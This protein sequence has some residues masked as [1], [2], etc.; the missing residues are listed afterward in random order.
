LRRD[1]EE[2]LPIFQ[3][4][5]DSRRHL[6]KWVP[7]GPRAYQYSVATTWNISVDV[8]QDDQEYG[9]VAQSLQRLF[10]FLNPDGILLEFLER[11]VCAFSD[12][13]KDLIANDVRFDEALQLLQRFS[14]I[15]I[16]VIPRSVTIHRMVQ[17]VIQHNLDAD[18]LLK[19]RDIIGTFFQHAYPPR[20]RQAK[21]TCMPKI[22]ESNFAISVTGSR[23]S[24]ICSSLPRSSSTCSILAQ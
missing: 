18:E 14:L 9:E 24:P 20:V 4:S 10:A 17:E 23:R 5:R 12:N 13:L 11:G 1:I 16:I 7:D 15:K 6:Y 19:A 2:Y 21:S 22:S 3:K 8:I